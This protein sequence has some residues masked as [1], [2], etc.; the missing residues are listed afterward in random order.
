MLL[1]EI[2]SF[3]ERRWEENPCLRG[4][5]LYY[6]KHF[7]MTP[8][9]FLECPRNCVYKYELLS[10]QIIEYKCM[11]VHEYKVLVRIHIN[12]QKFIEYSTL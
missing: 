11:C 7:E 2:N 6:S 8:T 1:C 12:T 10:V 4:L 3:T 5:P 9:P